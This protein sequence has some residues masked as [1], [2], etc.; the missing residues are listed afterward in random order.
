M[1]VPPLV[2]CQPIKYSEEWH[3][4]MPAYWT[5][6]SEPFDLVYYQPLLLSS[7]SGPVKEKGRVGRVE[8]KDPNNCVNSINKGTDSLSE[9]VDSFVHPE[10]H[11]PS[12]QVNS[13][14]HPEELSTQQLSQEQKEGPPPL[15]DKAT[16]GSTSNESVYNSKK[17]RCCSVV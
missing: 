5:P 17:N 15:L 16:E 13:I 11:S 8:S 10:E 9:Q 7:P 4:H 2:V 3:D 12:E 1:C 14:V 6:L